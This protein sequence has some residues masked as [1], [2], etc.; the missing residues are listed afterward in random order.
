M[1]TCLL[2][3][4]IHAIFQDCQ[5]REYIISCYRIVWEKCFYTVSQRAVHY[6]V[7]IFLSLSYI[8][9]PHIYTHPRSTT[10]LSRE[11][12]TTFTNMHQYHCTPLYIRPIKS[13]F[14][15]SL[16]LRYPRHT[17]LL[18]RAFNSLLSRFNKAFCLFYYYYIFY[19][20]IYMIALI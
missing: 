14:F 5:V 17:L 18:P 1:N 9:I 13:G 6:R 15:V 8:L 11:L 3:Y 19:C 4:Y 2:V 7:H 12:L 10:L 16:S 20:C